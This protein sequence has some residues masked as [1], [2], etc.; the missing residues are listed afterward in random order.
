VYAPQNQSRISICFSSCNGGGK[1]VFADGPL[2]DKTQ[3]KMLRLVSHNPK[4]QARL[5]VN[6]NEAVQNSDRVVLNNPVGNFEKPEGPASLKSNQASYYQA[7]DEVHF[8][9]EVIFAHHSGL[10]A[11]TEQAVLNTKTQDITGSQGIR[12]CHHENT[13]TAKS[14][15]I[16]TGENV[17]NFSG[18]VCL[19]VSRSQKN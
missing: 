19:N 9:E 1:F 18:D 16:Q 15:E 8:L 12:A 3:A 2:D 13:I 17:V 11:N 14:Y 5:F 4:T 10:V 7:D 6:A